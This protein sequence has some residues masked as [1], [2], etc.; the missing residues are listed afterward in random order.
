MSYSDLGTI[1]GRQIAQ[2]EPAGTSATQVFTPSSKDSRVVLTYFTIVND[3]GSNVLATIYHDADGTT[4]DSTTQIFRV[5][6]T[7]NDT[8]RETCYIPIAFGGNLAVQSATGS[9]LTF[10]LYGTDYTQSR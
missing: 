2:S 6:V 4:Y 5:S 10:S 8:L 3:T 1:H 7:A 9:A